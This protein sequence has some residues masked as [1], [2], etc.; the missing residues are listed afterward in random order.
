MSKSKDSVHDKYQKLTDLQHVLKRP[1]TYVGTT[2]TQEETMWVFNN[3][4]SKMEKMRAARLKKL[5]EAQIQNS[6]NMERALAEKLGL[7]MAP[8]TCSN[9]ECDHKHH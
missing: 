8:N 6:E 7:E 2:T 5:K 1:D 9:D 3:K 4:K